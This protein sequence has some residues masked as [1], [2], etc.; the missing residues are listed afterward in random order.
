MN[1]LLRIWR[2]LHAAPWLAA[3]L[4]VR[5]ALTST[6]LGFTCWALL[7]GF[8]W[9][10]YTL[11][12]MIIALSLGSDT[13][14]RVS[15]LLGAVKFSYRRTHIRLTWKAAMHRAR[16]FEVVH[17]EDAMHSVRSMPGGRKV[18]RLKRWGRTMIR[19]TP[20]GM[21]LTVDGSN[22]GA[23]LDAFKGEQAAILKAKWRALDIIVSPHPR[24]PY[25]LL[26]RVIFTDP[27]A[28]VISPSQLP[29]PPYPPQGICNVGNDSDG[30]VV[31]KDARLANLIAGAP[32]A[33]KSSECW[34]ILWSLVEQGLPFRTRVYDPKGGQE[35]WD[36]A[37]KAYRYEADPT[38]WCEFLEQA[39]A[40]M[41]AQQASLKTAGKR[42]WVP[43]DERWPLDV[44]IIDELVTV[45]AM[46]AGAENKVTIN[47]KKVPAL[48]A[49]LVY[50]SQG[51]AAG[52]TVLACTQL[53][54]K[55][56]IGLIRDLFAYVTCLRVGSD[57]MVKTIL[58]DPKM[59]PA[60]QIPA[61]DRWAGIGYMQDPQ[62]GQPV[63]YRAAYLED[64]ERAKVAVDVGV[65]TEKYTALTVHDKHQSGMPIVLDLGDDVDLD[66]TEDE[67][68]AL[69]ELV[70]VCTK[71]HVEMLAN[72]DSS[73]QDEISRLVDSRVKE[74]NGVH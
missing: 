58:G 52:F 18:P 9:P 66:V 54:Q 28:L 53:T 44:M 34:M 55:E 70:Q 32:G 11:L 30:H 61:G 67:Q 19:R 57:E 8:T 38:K 73:M 65:W 17:V 35:F 1:A 16:L 63:K 13:L 24:K 3:E 27:F 2:P 5:Y 49:F 25:W 26:L 56:A 40:A 41:A 6:L 64:D 10:V 12:A 20:A 74:L 69:D 37:D 7:G 68:A 51:R 59:Y 21:A 39:L 42:K 23:G 33:G 48:K 45:I 29:L 72:N 46:M 50:L 60:H 22:I 15:S 36:L 14:T 4:A 62:T 43:G 47:G 31:S 71:C